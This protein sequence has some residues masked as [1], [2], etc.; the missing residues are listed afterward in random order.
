LLLLLLEVCARNFG[1]LL[2]LQDQGILLLTGDPQ[3]LEGHALLDQLP[4]EPLDLH[5][6]ELK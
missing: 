3:V 5:F 2:Q 6:P 4:G 1:H